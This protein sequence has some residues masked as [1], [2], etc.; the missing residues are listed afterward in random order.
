MTFAELMCK[1]NSEDYK[2]GQDGKSTNQ[3]DHAQLLYKHYGTELVGL[4]R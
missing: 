4:V 1:K 3:Q 2:T